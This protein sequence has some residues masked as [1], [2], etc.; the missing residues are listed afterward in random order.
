MKDLYS[1]IG[2]AVISV[3]LGLG[4]AGFLNIGGQPTE[5][6]VIDE[7]DGEFDQIGLAQ[8][9]LEAPFKNLNGFQNISIDNTAN[10]ADELTDA[11]FV[12]NVANGTDL[13]LE[14]R[15]SVAHFEVDGAME[16][17]EVE[18]EDAATDDAY[19]GNVSLQ[20]VTLYDYDSAV[21]AGN[22]DSGVVHDDFEEDDMAAEGEVGTLTDGEY[23]LVSDYKFDSGETAPT[24]E[25]EEDQLNTITVEGETDGD[26]DTITGVYTATNTQ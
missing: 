25:D 24:A 14:E 6:S 12:W 22:V 2:I 4:A 23:A 8:D 3:A 26:V 1:Y 19:D 7:A 16:E 17:V 18:Y 13:G 11:S 9:K 20:D 10:S 21:D 15:T 5:A